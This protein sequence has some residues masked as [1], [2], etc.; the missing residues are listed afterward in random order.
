MK[1]GRKIAEGVAVD[2]DAEPRTASAEAPTEPENTRAEAP[3]TAEK[4]SEVRVERHAGV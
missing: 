3:V 1:L 4:R 2:L